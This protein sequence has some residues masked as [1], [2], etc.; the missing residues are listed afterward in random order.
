MPDLHPISC[1]A[2]LEEADK[3]VRDAELYTLIRALVA[4]LEKRG[5]T[6]NQF[7]MAMDIAEWFV[8]NRLGLP[9]HP[10]QAM[11]IF[12]GLQGEAALNKIIAR[13]EN[14]GLK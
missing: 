13:W 4:D 3:T 8:R 9:T 10:D 14:L 6:C 1:D 11:K 12:L 5:V 2:L 7:M